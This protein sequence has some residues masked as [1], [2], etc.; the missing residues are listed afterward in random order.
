MRISDDLR[1]CVVFLGHESGDDGSDFKAAGTA[2]FVAYKGHRYL[3]TAQHVAA[4]LGDDPFLMR[5]NREDGGADNVHC[6]PIEHEMRWYSNTADPSVDLSVLP[7]HIAFKANGYD[8][9]LLREEYFDPEALKRWGIGIGD[10]CY[11]VGLFRLMQGGKRN[12]PVVHTG[13]I[14]LMPGDERI[15]VRDWLGPKGTTNRRHVEGYLVQTQNLQGLSGSPVFVRPTFDLEEFPLSEDETTT[16]RIH[17][18][19]VHLLG[20]WT[21]SWDAPADEIMAVEVG[22]AVRVPVGFGTVAPAAKL[23]EILELPAIVAIRAEFAE[24]R[25]AAN[26][27]K[28]D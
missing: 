25:A 17:H 1:R 5:L 21:G 11:T 12:L 9:Q 19:G 16:A 10:V 27:A 6:D 20:V 8:G 2:F 23:I 24:K 13:Y 3:V 26:A 14:A 4:G 22:D 7:V 15:P 18:H 28:A